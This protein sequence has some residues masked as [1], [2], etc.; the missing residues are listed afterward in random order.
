[1]A[2][3]WSPD[4]ATIFFTADDQARSPILAVDVKTGEV[5]QILRDGAYSALSLDSA[6]RHLTS[7]CA[8]LDQPPEVYTLTGDIT[9]AK[10]DVVRRNVSQA[11]A[12]LLSE[13][14]L[15][16]PES[17]KV[18]VEGGDMQMWILKPPGFEV[19]KK[20]PLAYLVH[21]GPQGVWE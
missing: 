4:G 2:F 6:G 3:L 10:G 14:D 11:N 5:R 12:K 15:P 18:K 16:R 1:D 7:L 13:L 20:W 8:A 9:D 17:V 21:G 19:H